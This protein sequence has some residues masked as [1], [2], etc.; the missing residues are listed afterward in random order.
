MSWSSV[1][2]LGMAA[3]VAAFLG[4]RL[5]VALPSVLL[6]AAFGAF[7][8]AMAVRLA[9][10]G[11]GTESGPERPPGRPASGPMR[12]QAAVVG[13]AAVGLLSVLLGVGGGIVAIP[14][15]LHWARMDLHRVV[16]AS[17]GIITFA[18]LAGTAGY[19]AVGQ[20]VEGLPPHSLGFVHLPLFAAML[21]G[22][23]LLA[24]VGAGLNQRL[25]THVLRWVFA[26][27]L[28]VVGARLVWVHG[29]A[30][31]SATGS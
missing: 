5:A 24:P 26:G 6:K 12:W 17:L 15:L 2:A 10:E 18:A 30:L 23:V 20:G 1:F 14:I 11:G 7:L 25:P 31:L 19:A 22:A 9:R 13:G 3:G 4:A 29:G 16:P 27:L 28:L 8:V 21:P